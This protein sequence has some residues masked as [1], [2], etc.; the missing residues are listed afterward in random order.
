MKG[1]LADREL[2]DVPASIHI[3]ESMR[4]Q[5][6]GLDEVRHLIFAIPT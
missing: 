1:K 4:V 5:V 2:A 3:R 6:P